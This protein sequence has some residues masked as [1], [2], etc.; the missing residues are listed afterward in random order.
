MVRTTKSAPQVLS[1]SNNSQRMVTLIPR[2]SWW[3]TLLLCAGVAGYALWVYGTMPIGVE[4]HPDMQA[5]FERNAPAVYS[6]I[7][8]SSIA[9]ILGPF[10]FS[11]RLRKRLPDLHRWMGRIYLLAG[12][13]V[14]GLAGLYIARFAYGGLVT[15]VG[16]SAL[17][18]AWLFTGAMAYL[19]I[20]NRDVIA[21]RRWMIRNFSLTFAAVT[22][23]IY[24]AMFFAAKVEFG[25]FYPLLAWL[26]WVPNLLVAE[27]LFN[28]RL[29]KRG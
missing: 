6:H 14:G 15:S 5:A 24:L 9:L 11:T 2:A 26:C 21:H 18:I 28:D 29:L 17:A 1:L 13:F 3:L 20:R 22:L 19:S 16:F 7:F 23:R 27:W 8:A 25:V 12:I 10:Q 4:V